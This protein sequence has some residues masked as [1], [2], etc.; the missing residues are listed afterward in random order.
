MKNNKQLVNIQTGE[1]IDL[2]TSSHK[3][4]SEALSQV[5]IKIKELKYIE[6]V[7]KKHIKSLELGF[8]ENQ[9]GVLEAEFGIAKVRKSFRLGFDERKFEQDATEK[10]KKVVELAEKIKGKYQ[11]MTEVITISK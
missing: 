5:I 7:V 10:E 1:V 3:D 8:E 6:S 4:I 2:A 9:N 11:K